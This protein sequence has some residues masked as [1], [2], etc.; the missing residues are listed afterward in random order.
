MIRT[1]PLNPFQALRHVARLFVTPV[2]LRELRAGLRERRIVIIQSIYMGTLAA[3]T[4]LVLLSSV[5]YSR[6]TAPVLK[7]DAG[8]N[9]L[10]WTF[11][12]QW[13]MVVLVAPSLTCG[14]LSSEREK[15]TYEMLVA[16]LLS[17]G[18]IVAGKLLYGVAYMLLL[19]ISAL[20]ITATVF[21]L[22]GVSPGE[23]GVY[24][25]TIFFSG[26]MVCQIAL[27][28]SGREKRTATATNQSYGLTFL[29][30]ITGF[31]ILPAIIASR[32]MHRQGPLET[33]LTSYE[34]G[35]LHIP[36]AILPLATLLWFSLFLFIKT[37][38]A[39]RNSARH[40][41][42]LQRL[43]LIWATATV[44]CLTSLVCSEMPQ[45][46]SNSDDVGAYLAIVAISLIFFLGMLTNRPRLVAHRDRA[47]Y[48]QAVSSRLAFFPITTILL[49]GLACGMLAMQGVTVL[50][51]TT[52]FSIMAAATAGLLLAAL[53]LH[54]V[55]S[56]RIPYPV[57]YYGLFTMALMSPLLHLIPSNGTETT[58]S[59][60]SLW[61]ASPFVGVASPWG[62]AKPSMIDFGGSLIPVGDACFAWYA[63]VAVAAGIVAYA[64]RK[65]GAQR[66]DSV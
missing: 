36:Y 35:G 63:V 65:R 51:L 12:I 41:L 2:L 18:E 24:Y 25:S 44:F 19:L 40:V 38:N 31:G 62:D 4:L 50:P 26:L 46:S 49:F 37:M 15:Q 27:F 3:I 55:T 34:Y 11:S 1:R 57:C 6:P 53:A 32:Y 8:Q 47:L 23:I 20:P 61:F 42:W 48:A 45:T 17:P 52:S 60:W 14:L 56:R 7:Q 22:G 28:F 10:I 30:M 43:F 29:F 54:R 33:L 59:A 58:A 66:E 39:V 9:I 64:A 16:S 21:F 13:L 5:D